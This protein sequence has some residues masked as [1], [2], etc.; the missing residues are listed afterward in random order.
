MTSRRVEIASDWDVPAGGVQ[1]VRT[2]FLEP[3]GHCS[4]ADADSMLWKKAMPAAVPADAIFA[5][6]ARRP[7]RLEE[8]LYAMDGDASDAATRKVVKRTIVDIV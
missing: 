4:R 1:D 7:F 2:Q 6:A 3:S 5:M 8:G